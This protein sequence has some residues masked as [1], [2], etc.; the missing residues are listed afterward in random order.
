[1]VVFRL[2][3]LLLVEPL[4]LLFNS[5]FSSYNLTFCFFL[6]LHDILMSLDGC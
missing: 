6:L 1:M 5:Y 4:N 2:F 3:E